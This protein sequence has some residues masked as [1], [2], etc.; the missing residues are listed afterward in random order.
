[1][2]CYG[3]MPQL[4]AGVNAGLVTVAEIGDIKPNITYLSD[5]L[6]TAAR[7]QDQCE[8]FDKPLLISSERL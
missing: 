6:N 8:R 5:V 2:S 3:T 4:V 1:M 7:I